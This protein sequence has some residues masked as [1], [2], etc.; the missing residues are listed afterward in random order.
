MVRFLAFGIFFLLSAPLAAQIL[1][2]STQL[3]YGP[4]T[5]RYLKEENILYNDLTFINLD[6]S[7]VNSHR[8]SVPEKE[9]YKLQDL[10]VSGT[11]I[12]SIYPV[13]P[14]IIG[15]RSGFSAYAP[16]FRPVSD[17]RYYDTKSPY[18]KIKAA[19]GGRNRTAVDVGFNRSDSSNF[20]IGIDYFNINSD[21]QVKSQGKNDRLVRDEGYDAY[22]VYFTKK[23]RY[24]IMGNFSRM[25][26]QAIDQGG[27][28][29]T[30]S[31]PDYF[32]R[33]AS[34]YLSNASTEYLKKNYHVYHQL[35]VNDGFQIYQ[36]FD[37]SYERSSFN[38]SNPVAE[39][40]F[41]TFYLSEDVTADTSVFE[42]ISFE[43]GVKGTI[44]PL[45]Y[46]G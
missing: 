32:D 31:T 18:S 2:D 3:V 20:N 17:F 1:D 6:T 11:A 28:D 39:N 23:R 24:L 27:I 36:T 25:K 40:Y 19:I 46:S 21:K 30:G 29:I 38:D 37:R 26:T 33:D 15:A 35:R 22:L 4:S 5:T 7:V 44:G 42:T 14:V 45:F 10:G 8:W 43:N 34:V 12:R 16:Y 9:E 13:L 41:D